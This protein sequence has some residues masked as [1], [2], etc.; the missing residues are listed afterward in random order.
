[1]MFSEPLRREN[2]TKKGSLPSLSQ[3]ARLL[4]PGDQQVARE[5]V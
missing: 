1:M 3:L 4:P 5:I 2:Q